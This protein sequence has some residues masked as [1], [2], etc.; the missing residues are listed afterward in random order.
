MMRR[1]G[2]QSQGARRGRERVMQDEGTACNPLQGGRMEV[3]GSTGPTSVLEKVRLNACNVVKD[4][5]GPRDSKI[6]Q[7]KN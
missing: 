7:G 6:I 2:V 3:C 4:K 5:E 1:N